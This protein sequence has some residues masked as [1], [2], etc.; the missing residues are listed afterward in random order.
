L[1][2]NEEKGLHYLGLQ[3]QHFFV[4]QIL[5]S[6][7]MKHNNGFWKIWSF[8]SI[9]VTRLLLTCKNIWLWRLVIRQCP[10]VNFPFCSNLLEHVLL[11]IIQKTMNLH[12]LPSLKT[13]TII[14]TSFDLWMSKGGVDI[15]ALVINY[16][17]E[18]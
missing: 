18:S 10:C 16:L 1:T 14:S 9:K 5:I 7:V 8:T 3:S 4:Q 6:M 12:V 17:D 2:T 15:F 13:I 11:E